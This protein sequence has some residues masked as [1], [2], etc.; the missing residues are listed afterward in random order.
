MGPEGQRLDVAFTLCDM[1]SC[2]Q[3]LRKAVTSLDLFEHIVISRMGS[4][5]VSNML[6]K[7]LLHN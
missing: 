4:S 1:K 7:M 6:I 3:I 5:V 2:S